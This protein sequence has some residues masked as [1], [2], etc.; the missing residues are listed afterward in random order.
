MKKIT[1]LIA[2]DH[3]LVRQIWTVF[4]NNQ[5]RFLV[6]H[7]TGDASEAVFL[8]TKHAPD[9]VLMDISMQPL[10]GIEATKKIREVAPASRIIG[11]SVYSQPSYA[12]KILDAGAR[13]YVT[14]NSS[15]EE[16]VKAILDVHNGQKYICTE[17][18]SIIAELMLGKVHGE[19]SINELTARELEIIDLVKEGKSSREIG[20]ILHITLKTAEVHRHR[21]LKKLGQ[22]NSSAM[23][24]YMNT[25]KNYL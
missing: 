21:I 16:L 4:L 9:I 10:S 24:N 20:E 6:T 3:K 18:Q 7:S 12:R 8:A 2:D 5:E 1:I 15:K 11:V 19:K 14:K 13:G 17:I 25:S 23:I 22:P